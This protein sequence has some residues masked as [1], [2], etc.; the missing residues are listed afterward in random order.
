MWQQLL[1]GVIVLA[2]ASYVTWTFLPMRRRQRLLDALASRGLFTLRAR[3]HRA[4]MSAGACG[5]CSSAGEQRV[6]A[7]PRS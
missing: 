4:R 6:T 2:A 5:H 1:I 3:A 7:R